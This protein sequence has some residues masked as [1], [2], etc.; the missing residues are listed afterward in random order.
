MVVKSYFHDYNIGKNQCNWLKSVKLGR[1][2]KMLV[3][4]KVNTPI[5]LS[6]THF[7]QFQL[8]HTTA[9]HNFHTPFTNFYGSA[10]KK[11]YHQVSRFQ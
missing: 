11:V 1:K 7:Y 8:I 5:Y 3:D 4:C 10:V 9:T 2:A 6:L